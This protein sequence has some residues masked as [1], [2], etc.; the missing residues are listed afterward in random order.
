MTFLSSKKTDKCKRINNNVMKNDIKQIPRR[1][2][3]HEIT[4]DIQPIRNS[5]QFRFREI[6]SKLLPQVFDIGYPTRRSR[7]RLLSMRELIF[8]ISKHCQS[9]SAVL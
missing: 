1:S 3:T 5:S 4:G 6:N 2:R 9:K 7:F 8:E